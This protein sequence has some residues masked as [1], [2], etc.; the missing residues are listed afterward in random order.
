MILI[1]FLISNDKKK[2]HKILKEHIF[3]RPVLFG[4]R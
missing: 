4:I 1:I 3:K 2:S